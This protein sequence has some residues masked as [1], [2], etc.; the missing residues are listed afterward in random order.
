MRNRKSRQLPDH[1]IKVS[2]EFFPPKT[3][4]MEEK[5]WDAVNRLAPL[6][7]QFMD[8]TYGA[9]GSTRE[10]TH[11]VVT[12]MLAETDIPPVAHLTCVGAS[13]TEVNEVIEDYKAVGVK[14]I[15]ALRGDPPGGVGTKFE[16]HPDGYESSIELIKGIKEIGDFTVF[17]AGYPEKHPESPNSEA[18]IEWL[19]RK[20]DAGADRII[21]QFFFENEDFLRYLD[22]VQAAGINIP[23]TPGI[24]P[25][26]NF[27]MASKFAKMTGA[28]VP[29]WLEQR[30]D[31]LEGDLKT[32]S[33]VG[34][35]I[36]AEQVMELVDE[37]IN[38][39]H[40]YTLNRADLVFAI[41]S[42]LGIKS[43]TAD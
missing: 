39:F 3:E 13:K 28:R 20:V 5:L 6:R 25:V 43:E 31:G 15:V 16:P 1:E 27:K 19:K 42:M 2:F 36:C 38:E 33:Y 21:T 35:A 4:K 32:Q 41:C 9:G 11:E 24:Y 10:R 30:F 26:V 34:A 8:V 18:D 29:K 37:D 17:T 12:R 22:K 7:P 40:F 23:V 14:H